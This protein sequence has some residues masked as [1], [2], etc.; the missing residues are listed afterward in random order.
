MDNRKNLLPLASF[1]SIY[2]KKEFVL[3]RSIL[4][5][6]TILIK[7]HLIQSSFMGQ[8]S[9]QLPNFLQLVNTL[10]KKCRFW[11]TEYNQPWSES[12][13]IIRNE[14]LI[15]EICQKEFKMGPQTF[16]YLLNMIGA[17]IEKIEFFIW[18]WLSYYRG[19]SN[20]LICFFFVSQF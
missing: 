10:N 7:C 16:E 4:L 13:W 17:G 5:K 11:M 8:I 18:E 12:I 20:S 2:R 6:F 14:V 15:N 3:K 19:L 9:F 1:W